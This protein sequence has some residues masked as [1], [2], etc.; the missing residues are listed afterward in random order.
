MEMIVNYDTD[1]I[2][3]V[4]QSFYN[5]TGINI[6]LYRN[7]FSTIA[8]NT[9]IS[10]PYCREIQKC[11]IGTNACRMSDDELIKKCSV[12]KK[13][14]MHICHA[15]L[16][17]VAVP[18]MNDG[19]ILCY[20]ILGQMRVDSDF[21]A[22]AKKLVDIPVDYDK[23]RTCYM[24]LPVFDEEKIESIVNIATILAE[25]I[26]IG[27]ML[28]TRRMTFS[29]S[30][31]KYIEANIDKEMSVKDICEN[32]GVSKSALYANMHNFNGCTVSEYINRKRVEKSADMLSNTDYSVEMISQMCGF[33][34]SAYFSRTFK[35]IMGLSP[36]K[37]RKAKDAKN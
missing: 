19:D 10:T 9:R 29:E 35:K 3:T 20:I 22:V 2:N 5:A 12:S 36:L 4:L 7:D 37:Y 18:I 32:V 1:K 27:N 14:E 26:L 11:E 31:E 15:G 24:S 13:S 23:M 25:H 16:A 28:N 17:D 8:N 6:Q 34:S 30:V 33:S 21:D